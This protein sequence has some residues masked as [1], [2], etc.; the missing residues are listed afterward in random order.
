MMISHTSVRLLCACMYATTERGFSHVYA[1]ST[2]R[3][4]LASQQLTS[5]QPLAK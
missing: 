5:S 3:L 2:T 4:S 1:L